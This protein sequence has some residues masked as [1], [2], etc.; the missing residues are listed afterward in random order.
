MT[1]ERYANMRT[2]LLVGGFMLL[3][4]V[5]G[6]LSTQT[7]SLYLDPVSQDL[8]LSR[9]VL[10]SVF[11]FV[12]LSVIP[13]T[14]NLGRI[15]RVLGSYRALMLLGTLISAAGVLIGSF[16][17]TLWMFLLYAFG[18]Q[19]GSS[20]SMVAPITGVVN[21][22]FSQRQGLIIGLVFSCNSLGGAFWN[23]LSGIWITDWGWRRSFFVSALLLAAAAGLIF[24]LVRDEPKGA[25]PPRDNPAAAKAP[26]SDKPDIWRER[27]AWAL[28][29]GSFCMMLSQQGIRLNITSMLLDAGSTTVEAAS[30]TGI[31]LVA[32][33]VAL[34]FVGFLRDRIGIAAAR[35]L[36]FCSSV[37]GAIC[38]F[39]IHVPA[40]QILFSVLFGIGLVA[41]G[42]MTSLHITAFFTPKQMPYLFGMVAI[43]SSSGIFLGTPLVSLW[44]D[45]FGSYTG[46]LL[47]CMVFM[48]CSWFFYSRAEP[49][50]EAGMQPCPSD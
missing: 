4:F 23:Y 18:T 36:V 41:P 12:S 43:F 13:F 25:A 16:A 2:F 35:S 24:L 11:S 5:G 1:D 39:W 32:T 27:R 47:L 49:K 37:L 31:M 7:R 28:C 8:S 14:A 29:G 26:E 21:N 48:C 22:W 42:I 3:T 40:M 45:L 15:K 20:I 44:Y 33:A 46:A 10:S 34:V 50:R 9:S 17:S 6:G 30:M 38:L 19:L